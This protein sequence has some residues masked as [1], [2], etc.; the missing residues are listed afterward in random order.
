MKGSIKTRRDV[1]G[2]GAG[3]VASATLPG[4]AAAQTTATLKSVG[5]GKGLLVGSACDT[6]EIGGNAQYKALL[7]QHS[8][9]ITPTW[10]SQMKTVE[11]V[12]GTFVWPDALYNW[13]SASGMKMRCHALQWYQLTPDWFANVAAGDPAKRAQL[14]YIM[15]F[16]SHYRGRVWSWDVVNEPIAPEDGRP[17]GLRNSIWLQKIGADYIS[18]AFTLAHQ[19]DASAVLV[20]NEYGLYYTHPYHELRRQALLS[21]LESLVYHGVPIHALG[22]QSHLAPN[23]RWG[24]LDVTRFGQFL[25]NVTNLGLKLMITEF[26]VNDDYLPADV[27]TRDQM[28]CDA[29]KQYL[30]LVLSYRACISLQ[31]WGSSD[32]YSW[33]N[34]S[35]PR[36]DG[37]QMRPLPFDCDLQAKP[38]WSTIASSIANAPDR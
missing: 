28:V 15:N 37:Q 10:E 16:V 25:T 4:I 29:A 3:L 8:A 27:A 36:T 33:L 6:R 2:L 12:Q 1:L 31:T 34:W 32:R 23:S 38:L 19:A 20:L 30:D 17:D 11:P 26:D 9:V 13:C 24:A 21:L 22:I 18:R 5:A 7:T 14:Q 35:S